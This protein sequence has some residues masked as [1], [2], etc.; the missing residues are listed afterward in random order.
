MKTPL[1]GPIFIGR[2][3]LEY[4]KMFNLDLK[5]LSNWS[6]LDCAAG[7]SSFTAYMFKNHLN[8]IAVDLKYDKTPEFLEKMCQQ[9][10]Q[11][12]VDSLQPLQNHFEWYFFKDL[13]ELKEHR[14][15]SCQEFA[16]DY[17]EGWRKRYLK[18]DLINLPFADNSFDLVL[19]A[20]L[21][22]IYD[23]RLSSDFHLKA[24]QEMMRVTKNQLRLYPLV[25]HKGEKSVMV[26]KVIQNLPFNYHAQ[27]VPVDYKFRRGGNEMLVISK[28]TSK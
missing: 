10:L 3:W 16:R 9:H 25:K 22:F 7:A 24:V 6:I 26:H 13:E 14:M 5:E 23:H 27:I 20:H 17:Q 28:K 8:C 1:K 11:V 12:L 19:C 4:L 18:A 21:L 2:S 15:Q